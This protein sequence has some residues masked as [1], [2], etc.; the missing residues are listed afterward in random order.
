MS[1]FLIA[2]C[3]ETLN[4]RSDSKSVQ[5]NGP[6]SYLAAEMRTVQVKGVQFRFNTAGKINGMHCTRLLEPADPHTWDDN[7]L[8]TSEKI[9]LKFSN[10][11]TIL[12]KDCYSLNEPSDAAGTWADNYLCLPKNSKYKLKFSNAGRISGQKCLSML[13]AAEPKSTTWDDN[14]LCVTAGVAAGDSK[15]TKLGALVAQFK[16]A[17]AG[18]TANCVSLTEPSDPHTWNDNFICTSKNIGLK[19]SH[20]GPIAGMKCSSM[21]E[22]SDRAGT[23]FDNYLCVPKTSQY[24]L[25]F[26]FA[27]K[28]PGAKCLSMHEPAEPRHTAWG[29]NYLCLSRADDIIPA[30]PGA[31]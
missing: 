7:Y 25:Q 6:A 16:H 13:E 1:L 9:G 10:A 3:G 5:A 31:R 21:N 19:F 27:G 12:G 22:P 8:C 17:G 14:Y 18:T 28:I 29:D 20:I 23:W 26:S 11:G 30:I 24:K 15:T 2:S 4:L